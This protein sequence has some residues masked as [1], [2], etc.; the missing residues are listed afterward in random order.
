MTRFPFSYEIVIA[1]AKAEDGFILSNTDSTFATFNE[2]RVFKN[3]GEVKQQ[4][5]ILFNEASS[6]GSKPKKKRSRKPKHKA[7]EEH[8]TP[9][10]EAPKEDADGDKKEA[11]EIE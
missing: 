6:R 5:A 2:T 4:L 9:E 1:I 11:E 7:Q 10:P 8:P 3:I